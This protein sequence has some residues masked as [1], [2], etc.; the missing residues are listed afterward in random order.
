MVPLIARHIDAIVSA[1]L[2]LVLLAGLIRMPKGFVE[3][4]EAA[5]KRRYHMRLAGFGMLI[6]GGGLFWNKHSSTPPPSADVQPAKQ[7]WITLKET[8]YFKSDWPVTPE[9]STVASEAGPR[10]KWSSSDSRGVHYVV[11]CTEVE[12]EVAVP[13]SDDLLQELREA[14]KAQGTKEKSW[15]PTQ[16]GAHPGA[17]IVVDASDGHSMRMENIATVRRRYQLIAAYPP[18]VP[19]DADLFFKSFQILEPAP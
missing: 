16:R 11:Q 19:S 17:Q 4:A 10:K 9:R 13:T 3:S 1:L 8:G 6:L 7:A 15:K 2:G 14:S 12:G 5:S 18:G